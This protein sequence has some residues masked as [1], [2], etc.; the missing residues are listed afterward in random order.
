MKFSQSEIER[1]IEALQGADIFFKKH[2]LKPMNDVSIA[3]LEKQIQLYPEAGN[4]CPKCGYRMLNRKQN[5][6]GNCGQ[7]IRRVKW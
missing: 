5:Y 7:A 1:E 2:G 3:A 6:C 4:H